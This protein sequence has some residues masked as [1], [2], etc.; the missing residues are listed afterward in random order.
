M[1]AADG[2]Q[3]IGYGYRLA[4]ELRAPMER[5]EGGKHF[6]PR[7]TPTGPPRP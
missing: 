1:G 7:T 4:Y 6:V 2:F 3:P 5:V